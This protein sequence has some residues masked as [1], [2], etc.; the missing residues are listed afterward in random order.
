[1][2]FLISSCTATE[3]NTNQV[4]IV[5]ENPGILSKIQY[6]LQVTG[7][8]AFDLGLVAGGALW[9]LEA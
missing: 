7:A 5:D 3:E 2:C 4:A 9:L 6:G 8:T 1:M